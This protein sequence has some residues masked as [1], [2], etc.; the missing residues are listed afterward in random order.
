MPPLFLTPHGSSFK[1]TGGF[2]LSMTPKCFLP[3]PRLQTL[4]VD[5]RY[6]P[7][8][9]LTLV[10]A[11]AAS[12]VAERAMRA[13]FRLVEPHG[14]L[15]KRSR[16]RFGA[17]VGLLIQCLSTLTARDSVAKDG[18]RQP[19]ARA[20]RGKVGLTDTADARAVPKR[21]KCRTLDILS[22]AASVPPVAVDDNDPSARLAMTADGGGVTRLVA[23]GPIFD[24]MYSKDLTVTAACASGGATVEIMVTKLGEE[25]GNALKNVIWRP[26]VTVTVKP[27]RS[28][29]RVEIVWRVHLV[30][31][32][33]LTQ[34]Q[35]LGFPELDYPVSTSVTLGAERTGRTGPQ[36]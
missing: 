6:E 20:H 4:A 36:K 19:T 24:S 3:P 18:I 28:P 32:P 14:R 10:N 17:A 35:T 15:F 11:D 1:L 31:G 23:T 27:R 25:T 30:G 7:A 5:Q 12:L 9:R 26:S 21:I 16:L 8:M 22:T 2:D 34:N 13:S 29:S 33:E